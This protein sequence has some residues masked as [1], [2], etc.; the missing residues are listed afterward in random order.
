MRAIIAI[1]VLA[2]LTA[3][4]TTS[5]TSYNGWCTKTTYG[6]D[7]VERISYVKCDE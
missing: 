7:G 6:F 5:T 3:C 4:S 1:A 2:A